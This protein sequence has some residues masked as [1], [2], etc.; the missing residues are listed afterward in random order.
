MDKFEIGDTV[1][2]N[3]NNTT[4]VIE[5]T[6]DNNVVCVWQ[7]KNGLLHREVFNQKMIQKLDN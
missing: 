3:G 7:D 5:V 2:L 1:I 6:Y 4:M